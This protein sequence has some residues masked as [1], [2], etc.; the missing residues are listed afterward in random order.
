[1]RYLE[2]FAVGD[3]VKTPSASLPEE[4]TIAFAAKY[5]PQ[6]MHLDREA[7]ASGPLN[8]LSASGWHTAAVVMRL[9][10]DSDVLWGGQILGL[11]VDELRWPHPARPG[12]V[13]A[14][15]LETVSVTPSRSRP[16]HG[17]V[18]IRVTARNQHGVIVLTMC[19]NLWVSRRPVDT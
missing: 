5:D 18:R 16:T 1:M 3:I 10:V 6:A 14:A 8:G 13:L 4:E 9:I 2:D 19:P 17:V 12:D 11:G 15:E 7:A